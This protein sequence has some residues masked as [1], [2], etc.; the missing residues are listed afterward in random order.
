M[1]FVLGAY[2]VYQF[3]ANYT[4]FYVYGGTSVVLLALATAAELDRADLAIAYTLQ[5]TALLVVLRQ[6]LPVPQ[7]LARTSL[8]FAVPIALSMDL[9]TYRSWDSVFGSEFA[10][11]AILAAAAGFTLWLLK[12]SHSNNTEHQDITV[13]RIVLMSVSVGYSALLVWNVSHLL[14]GATGT[15]VALVLYALV[16]VGLLVFSQSSQQKITKIIGGC[17]IGFVVGRLL[18]ID[19]WD[20]PIELRIVTFVIIGVLLISTAFIGKKVMN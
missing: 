5:I 19:V 6:F 18:L 16:G 4:A 3:T 9:L 10:T 12:T 11:L 14:L 7:I 20:M 13:I 8:L 2:V 15:V 17:F 1:A